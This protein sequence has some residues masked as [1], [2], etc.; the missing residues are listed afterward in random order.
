MADLNLSENIEENPV[1]ETNF[2]QYIKENTTLDFRKAFDGKIDLKT[3]ISPYDN[4]SYWMQFTKKSSQEWNR[5]IHG[6]DLIDSSTIPP[7]ILDSW[8]R[9]KEKK[10]NPAGE[11]QCQILTGHALQRLLDENRLLIDT[12]QPFLNRLFQSMKTGSFDV[13]LFDRNGYLLQVMQDDRYVEINRR[14]KWY[15]GVLWSEDDCGSNVVASVLKHKKPVQVIGPQHYLQWCHIVTGS[16]APII[17][18]DGELIGGIAIITLLFATHPHTLGMAISAAQAIENEMRVQNAYGLQKAI[19]TSIPEALI[20]I[21]IEGRI[22]TINKR[23][24]KLF[25]LD[26]RDVTGR[27]LRDIYPDKQNLPFLNMIDR[28]ESITDAE[29]RILSPKGPGDYT[30]TCNSTFAADGSVIGQILIFSEIQRIKSLV[31]KFVGAKANFKFSDIHGENVFFKSVMEE[32]RVIS[33]STSNVLLLGESGT[34]K[35][36]LAQAIHNASPRKNGPYVAIN[37]AAIPRDLIASELFG[38]A[39]GAF[40]GSRRGGNQGKFELADGG[41]IFLDEIA[42]TPLEIQAALLRVIED[43]C[44][45]RIG[46]NHVRTV[47]VRIISATNKN[48]IEEVN[49]GNFRK[50]LYYRLNVF[51]IHLP[52]LRERTD[53]IP[54]LV[55]VFIKKYESTLRKTI[56]HVDEKVLNI[57]LQHSWPG[58]VRELQNVVER[59][60]NY[61]SSSRL[62]PS[63]IPPE[64]ADVRR[65][66]P[67]LDLESPEEK[68]KRLIRHMLTLKFSKNNIAEQLGMSR[69]TLFRKIKKYGLERTMKS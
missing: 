64:I 37:C 26:D 47:D 13:S 19:I 4:M 48:L 36:I 68:E 51:N 59:M 66:H 32:A 23:A 2:F 60:V 22:T 11:P 41:T 21:N 31:N 12:S 40:T 43:K 46:G 30:L 61:A 16:G 62:T 24:Q 55:D 50:D 57:F 25:G 39:E 20:A 3:T 44:V 53:D 18:P 63:L 45:T 9:S 34:G 29:V 49:T 65:A 8:R 7:A 42:E 56:S 69:T 5:F 10:L 28:R 17:D 1:M 58:N 14:Y 38:Y 52:P 35:D 6:S 67:H 33:K 54:L 27:L 15:P